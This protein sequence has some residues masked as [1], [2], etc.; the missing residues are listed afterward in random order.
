M[1]MVTARYTMTKL[2]S[3]AGFSLAIGNGRK[4]I[5]GSLTASQAAAKR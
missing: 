3:T 2:I 1:V 5:A 4:V